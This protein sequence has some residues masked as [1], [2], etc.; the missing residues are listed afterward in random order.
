MAHVPCTFLRRFFILVLAAIT[1][2]TLVLFTAGPGWAEPIV[3]TWYGPGFEETTTASGEPFDPSDYTAA[4]RTLP[5]G[6]KLVVTYKDRSVVVRVNDRGP[7][8]EAEIDL[9]QAAAEYIGLIEV[10][11]ATVDVVTADPGTPTG[12]YTASGETK[13]TQNEPKPTPPRD[14]TQGE[15]QGTS[16]G[17]KESGTVSGDLSAD[18]AKES[19]TAAGDLVDKVQKS[20]EKARTAAA[21][22]PPQKIVVPPPPELVAPRSTVE[23]R[24]KLAA[25]SGESAVE[26]SSQLA[27]STDS[28][29]SEEN[30]KPIVKS[31]ESSGIGS[32]KIVE[33]P[34]TGG[35][36]VFGLISGGILCGLGWLLLRRIRG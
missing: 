33:L 15:A 5:F 9:T 2:L 16:P 8:S 25:Q 10:G 21:P 27:S 3:A 11:T 26:Q 30:P 19:G 14:A 29:F 23:R 13:E 20:A 12:P 34:K 36:S 31:S 32:A 28:E 17:T 6:T 22:P 18:G 7:F 35:A 1:S 24:L 4:H